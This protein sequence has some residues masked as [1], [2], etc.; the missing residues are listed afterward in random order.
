[1]IQKMFAVYDSKARTFCRPFFVAHEAVALRAFEGGANDPAQEMCQ[2][3]GDFTLFHLGEFDDD[4]GVVKPL[5]EH[6]NLG[7]AAQ[8]KRS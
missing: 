8:F 5:A 7:L 3:P 1:M 2:H 6:V 4:T